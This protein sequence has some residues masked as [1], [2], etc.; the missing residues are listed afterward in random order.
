MNNKKLAEAF[1]MLAEAIEDANETCGEIAA[2][3]AES[4][5]VTE[6]KPKTQAAATAVKKEPKLATNDQENW[7]NKPVS[8]RKD[9]TMTNTYRILLDEYGLT[10]FDCRDA[11]KKAFRPELALGKMHLELKM[12]EKEGLARPLDDLRL[13]WILER[14]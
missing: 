3:K 7:R 4:V 12:L 9:P 6:A 8:G 10:Q 11:R 5:I 1:R 13:L 14:R 2:P